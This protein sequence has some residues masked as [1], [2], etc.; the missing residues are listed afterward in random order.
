MGE[1][2]FVPDFEKEQEVVRLQQLLEDIKNGSFAR[3]YLLYGEE[4]YLRLQYRDKLKK[5][6]IPDGDTMNYHYFEGKGIETAQLIDLAET[7]PFFAERRVIVVENSGL[8]KKATE[9]LAEYFKAPA[10]SVCF[11]FVE[12]EVDKRGR[13]YKAVR[14]TGRV[15]EFARQNEATEK[16]RQTDHTERSSVFSAAGRFG[17]G[18]YQPGA[19]KAVLL[20]DGTGCDYGGRH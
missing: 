20:Y 2:P 11:V 15:V 4:T 18:K 8:F 14:D 17:Y 9:D 5:A 7:L 6:L 13:L 16:R 12:T 19:G 10:P 1:R 3:V